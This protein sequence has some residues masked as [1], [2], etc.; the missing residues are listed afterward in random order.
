MTVVTLSYATGTGLWSTDRID[1]VTVDRQQIDPSFDDSSR[2]LETCATEFAVE[3]AARRL[4]LSTRALQLE[5]V[6]VCL[7][8][9]RPVCD[10]RCT[11]PVISVEPR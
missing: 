10:V 7:S 11:A 4:I 8:I 2:V 1:R 6:L 3:G 9:V 5:V